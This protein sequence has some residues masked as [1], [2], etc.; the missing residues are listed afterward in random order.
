MDIIFSEIENINTKA[1]LY[2]IASKYNITL[3]CKKKKSLQNELLK[4]LQDSIIHVIPITLAEI[5]RIDDKI[6]YRGSDGFIYDHNLQQRQYMN[7]HERIDILE[8]KLDKLL[9]KF[10]QSD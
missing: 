1:D 9:D 8:H 4:K 10:V 5:T 6:V 3:K 2:A 7:I